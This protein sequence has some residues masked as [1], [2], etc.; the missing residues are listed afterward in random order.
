M[1][2]TRK[3]QVAS[4]LLDEL[5]ATDP[6]TRWQAASALAATHTLQAVQALATA[7]YDP[8]PFVRWNAAQALG[9]IA[10]LASDPAVP[11]AVNQKVLAAAEAADPGTRA[12]AADAVA[13][14]GQ[15]GPLEPLLT[16]ARDPEPTVRAAAVRALGLAGQQNPQIV[17]PSLLCALNDADPEVR[18]MAAN[19]SA[20]CRDGR[21]VEALWARLGDPVGTVRAAALRALTRVIF[22]SHEGLVL[23]LLQDPDPAVRVEAVRFLRQHGAEQALAALAS[24]EDDP[25]Q[26]GNVALGA[27]AREARLRI[28]RRLGLWQE[29]R[30]RW[31]QRQ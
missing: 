15:R 2:D 5:Q 24:L 11:V 12:S 1:A 19:A 28:A 30:F 7:L 29:L 23:P 26:V 3:A 27:L 22:G 31:Q 14:W 16:L 9:Q 25:T 10:R 13:A 17:I 18:R 20:W 4:S 21:A 8:E 6:Q